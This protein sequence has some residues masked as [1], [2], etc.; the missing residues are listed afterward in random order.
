MVN[1]NP[2]HELI[3]SRHNPPT[4]G[5]T[6]SLANTSLPGIHSLMKKAQYAGYLTFERTDMG[7]WYKYRLTA[8]G[9]EFL[10]GS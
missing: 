2:L 3:R 5:D 6:G 9:A 4:E 1:Y 10:S 8:K 7:T